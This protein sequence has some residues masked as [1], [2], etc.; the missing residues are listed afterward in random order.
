MKK[1]LTLSTLLLLGTYGYDVS[2]AQG[3]S[4]LQ[5]KHITRACS[6]VATT[7]KY[8]AK[9][10]FIDEFYKL[11]D[12]AERDT[13]TDGNELLGLYQFINITVVSSWI[14]NC[15][16]KVTIEFYNEFAK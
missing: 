3:Q 4:Q 16:K 14:Q 13:Y 8:L 11:E 7:P 15:E 6:V 5:K 12:L 2:E 1:L 10:K 9:N